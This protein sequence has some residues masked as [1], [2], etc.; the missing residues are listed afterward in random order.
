[1]EYQKWVNKEK[2]K[3]LKEL[4]KRGI[5]PTNHPTINGSYVTI[6]CTS[7]YY[8]G[9][10]KWYINTPKTQEDWKLMLRFV[11]LEHLMVCPSPLNC[12]TLA[13]LKEED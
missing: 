3:L 13:I 8:D 6:R 12:P 1:M 7:P 10:R 2:E 4:K 5:Y 9:A 11:A